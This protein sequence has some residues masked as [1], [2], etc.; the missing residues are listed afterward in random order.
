MLRL[1]TNNFTG[2]AIS[3]ARDLAGNVDLRNRVDVMA[4]EQFVGQNVEELGCTPR[5]NRPPIV[6]RRSIVTFTQNGESISKN[7]PRII[8]DGA[9]PNIW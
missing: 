4:I 9:M 1:R 6:R 5:N 3:T 8:T 7:S 2:S